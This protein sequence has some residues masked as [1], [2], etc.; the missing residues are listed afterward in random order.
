MADELDVTGISLTPRREDSASQE[1]FQSQPAERNKASIPREPCRSW[2]PLY[3]DILSRRHSINSFHDRYYGSA[4]IPRRNSMALPKLDLIKINLVEKPRKSSTEDI[5]RGSK[6]V[7][8]VTLSES[9]QSENGV[10]LA[11]VPEPSGNIPLQS[12]TGNGEEGSSQSEQDEL[13]I[14][15]L[16]ESKRNCDILIPHVSSPQRSIPSPKYWRSERCFSGKIEGIPIT[17][18]NKESH[19]E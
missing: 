11:N 15:C 10:G 8:N 2:P 18:N 4:S 1:L 13:P 3:P 6:I 17:K 7:G 19:D 5:R 9:S 16:V 12:S 14:R